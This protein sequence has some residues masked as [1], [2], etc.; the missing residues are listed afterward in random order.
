M[1]LN[2]IFHKRY[3][4]ILKP[5]RKIKR[6]EFEGN[7]E[8]KWKLCQPDNHDRIN[9]LTTQMKYRLYQGD[10][11][12]IYNIGYRDD[13]TPVGIPHPTLYDTLKIFHQMMDEL[14]CHVK[15]MKIFQ[16]KKGYCANIYIEKTENIEID[17]YEALLDQFYTFQ[18]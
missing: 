10:G 12:A 4:R 18:I 6:E 3:K 17:I 13:G 8:Y 11:R 15:S 2:E 1:T 14:G 7:I 16:G 9:H 5:A